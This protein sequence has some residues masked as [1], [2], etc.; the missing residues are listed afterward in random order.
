[1]LEND[2]E[3]LVAVDQNFITDKHIQEM[4]DKITITLTQYSGMDP[5]ARPKLS[6]LKCSPNLYRFV[7]LFNENILVDIRTLIYWT[8]VVTPEEPILKTE[9][10]TRKYQ[11][12][13]W[14]V[15]KIST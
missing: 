12:K 15:L 1:M 14:G 8:A 10:E 13:T 4:H 11:Q 5:A 6:K 2:I 3:T 7:N 9:H